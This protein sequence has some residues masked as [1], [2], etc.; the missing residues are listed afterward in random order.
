MIV[1]G[2]TKTGISQL[3]YEI[4]SCMIHQNMALLQAF[5]LMYGIKIPIRGQLSRKGPEV[6]ISPLFCTFHVLTKK[7]RAK[8]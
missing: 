6:E 2:C 1:A 5:Q 8:S 7:L 4:Y 3:K